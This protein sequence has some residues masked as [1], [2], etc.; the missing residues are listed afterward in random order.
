MKIVNPPGH[1]EPLVNETFNEIG[2]IQNE[3]ENETIIPSVNETLNVTEN[4]TENETLLNETIQNETPMIIENG[5]PTGYS[6]KEGQEAVAYTFENLCADTCSLSPD[7]N[8]TSYVIEFET[9]Q[10][11]LYVEKVT[12][13]YVT[14]SENIKTNISKNEST[15]LKSNLILNPHFEN[16]RNNNLPEN[17]FYDTNL[18]FKN[19]DMVD[20]APWNLNFFRTRD[21]GLFFDMEQETKTVC[22][23]VIMPKV[24]SNNFVLSSNKIYKLQF[25]F[26][27]R[28]TSSSTD[29]CG[30]SFDGGPLFSIFIYGNSFIGKIGIT[31]STPTNEIGTNQLKLGDVVDDCESGNCITNVRITELENGF[32]RLEGEIS[33]NNGQTVHLAI[34]DDT[35]EASAGSFA[36]LDNFVIE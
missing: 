31:N 16:T 15:P 19:F 29:L 34:A 21:N 33:V 13:E 10:A 7:F 3:T 26:S 25:D 6:I 11:E 35:A 1:E 5:T 30:G 18:E 17:W 4:I 36:I 22:N 12:Y 24:K 28:Y 9:N 14:K 32:Y 2:I 20:S 8:K 27:G 23:E